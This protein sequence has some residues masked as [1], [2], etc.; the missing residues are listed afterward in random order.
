MPMSFL[1][2]MSAISIVLNV[3]RSR[4][5]VNA[6]YRDGTIGV[7]TGLPSLILN[8]SKMFSTYPL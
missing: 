2:G 5:S 3:V 1:Y 6:M 7:T 4:R 8:V